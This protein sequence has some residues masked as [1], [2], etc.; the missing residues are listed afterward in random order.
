MCFEYGK[1]CGNLAGIVCKGYAMTMKNLSIFTF[2]IVLCTMLVPNGFAQEKP[3]AAPV[4]KAAP[5][6]MAMNATAPERTDAAACIAIRVPEELSRYLHIA[7]ENSPALLTAF[8]NWKAAAEKVNQEGY[9][10]NP[11]VSLGWYLEPVQTRTGNQRFSIGLAQSFPW[12]GKLSLQERQ[13]ALEADALKALL[14]DVAFRIFYTVKRVY[15]EYAYVARAVAINRETLNLITYLEGVVRSRYESG[16]AGYSDVIRLQVE[17]ATLE[18]RISTLEELQPPLVAALN[19]AMGQPMEQELPW[20]KSVPLMISS[21]KDDEILALLDKGAPRLV[22]SNLRVTK[23]EAGVDL[24]RKDYFPDFT[25]SLS[26]I[27]T[28]NTALRRS[29]SVTPDGVNFPATRTTEGAGNDP[30]IAGLSVK[31]PI[32]FG[33]NAAGVREAKAKKRAAMSAEIDLKKTLEADLR[34]ALSKYRDANRQ[35][36]LY[37]D[38]LIPKAT[39]ALGATV[40]SYQSG[41]ATIGDF[42]QSETT[43][44]E[45]ELAQARALSEQAQRLAEMESI[46]GKEIP[47][48][49]HGDLI[50]GKLTPPLNYTLEA[51]KPRLTAPV[52]TTRNATE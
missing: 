24:A 37:T 35:V 6:T 30:V 51:E 22:A 45:L 26:T 16:L 9:L 49:V 40:E 8:E 13:A 46:L 50:G 11:T 3:P 36:S 15:Y 18:D 31:L 38:T 32:W 48:A 19:A 2:T 20:P 25:L 10:P 7:A 47:C 34:M 27:L 39:Q 21:L 1:S 43:L 14:D 23:A 28:D 42:L 4:Q 44:L 52:S 29:Q 41:L 5:T 12:F 17:L 33:K